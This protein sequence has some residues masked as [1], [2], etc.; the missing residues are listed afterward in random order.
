MDPVTD[1]YAEEVAFWDGMARRYARGGGLQTPALMD[2]LL[3]EPIAPV[4]CMDLACGP[5]RTTARLAARFPDADVVGVDIS[6]AMLEYARREHP[7]LRFERGRDSRL[8]AEDASLDLVTISLGL[9]LFPEPAPAL[10]EIA[11]VLRPGGELRV[12]VWGRPEHTNFPT[13]GLALARRLG[14]DLPQPPRSNFHLGTPVALAATAAD[15]RL[16]LRSSRYHRLLFRYATGADACLDM[17]LTD[18]EP[19]FLEPLLGDAWDDF[20]PL[21]EAEADRLLAAG[22]G[23][24]AMDTLVGTFA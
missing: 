16:E 8:P 4:R 21:A 1:P 14:H 7:H 9:M 13:F 11:R 5:G 20:K 18:D 17:G 23:A 2:E 10:A 12:A 3:R 15:T 22:D 19:G 6:P 24:L